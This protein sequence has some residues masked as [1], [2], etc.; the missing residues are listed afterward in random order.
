MGT[1]VYTCRTAT[2]A[3]AGITIGH[4][5]F[6]YKYG[7]EGW[8][9]DSWTS[10]KYVRMIE[11]KAQKARASRAGEY[12]LYIQ[13]VKTLNKKSIVAVLKYGRLAVYSVHRSQYQVIEEFH[14]KPFGYLQFGADSK[15]IEFVTVTEQE[16]AA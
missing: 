9:P 11:A 12:A 14:N 15:T 8:V 13:G 6:A 3:I 10:N 2:L 16:Q 7:S 1:Y 4:F 5:D